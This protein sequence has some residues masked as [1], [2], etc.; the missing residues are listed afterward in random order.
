[1]RLPLLLVVMLA[2]ARV[3]RTFDFTRDPVDKSPAGWK[4]VTGQWTIVSD[5]S[6]PSQ[7]HAFAQQAKSD[8]ATFNLVVAEQPLVKHVAIVVRVKSVAGADDQGGGPV[9][10]YGDPGNYYVCRVNPLESNFRVYK[11]VNGKRQQLQSAEVKSKS[12]QWHTLKVTMSVDRIRC[13]LDGKLLLNVK[14]HT[15]MEAGRVGLWT[16]ADAETHFDDLHVTEAPVV[17]DVPP[18]R[19]PL[20]P[21]RNDQRKLPPPE[22]RPKKR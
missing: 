13:W 21:D 2:T 4:V 22:L 5:A 10:R 11:V 7:P 16:K 17:S 6:A 9:W 18:K 8:G 1:M 19:E 3:E 12:G 15:F 14:D 20:Q